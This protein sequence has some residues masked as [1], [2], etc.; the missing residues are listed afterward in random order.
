[1]SEHNVNQDPQGAVSADAMSEGGLRA[2]ADY[3]TL[4]KLW[5]WFDFLILVKLARLRF[6][7]ILAVIGAA[8]L[9]W[10]TAVAYYEKWTRPISGEAQAADP[11]VE[12][13]CPM[14]PQVVTHDPHEKCPICGMNLSKRKKDDT[15]P[16]EA[17]PP[18]VVT[19]LQLSPYKVVTAGVRTWEANYEPL[20]KKLQTVGTVEV[21][22]RRQNR[23]TARVKGRLDKLYVNVTGQ[24]VRRGDPLAD[25]YSPDLVS[26]VQNLLDARREADKELVRDRLRKWGVG[27]DQVKEMERAGKP[28]EH[29]TI[30]S[31]ADGYVMKKYQVEGESVEE[32][33]PLYDVADLSAVWVEAK[34]YEKDVTFLKVGLPV[35]ATA[36]AL[37]NREFVGN[38]A[39]IYPALEPGSRTLKVRF[40]IDNPD[41]EKRPELGLRPKMYATVTIDVPA[42]DLAEQY[43]AA[44]GRVLGVPE[45]AVVYTG[46]QKVVFRQ[47][48][49]TVFDA[50]AV[51]VGPLLTRPDGT[52]FYPV[53]K[54]L[55]AGDHVVT[56]GSYLLDAETRVSASA[57]SIYSGGGGGGPRSGSADLANVRPTTPQDEDANVKAYLAQLSSPDRRLAEAQKVCP[58]QKNRLGTMGTPVKLLLNGEPVFLCCTGCVKD[59]ET[60]PNKTLAAVTE[61]KNGD[62]KPSAPALSAD[63]AAKVKANLAKLGDEDRKLAEA[64]KYCALLRNSVLGLMGK[65]VKV[66]IKRQPVFLCCPNCEDDA[67]ADPD[68]TLKTAEEQKKRAKA[69]GREF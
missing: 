39:F 18:G 59:A 5:W 10:D 4:R 61:M 37:P 31:T 64:Q 16:A 2:P 56:A 67:R 60:D 49:P 32:S 50:V 15:A 52:A 54:G 21:D 45:G 36:D 65:P 24:A 25:I 58:V 6:I 47:E 68:K 66:V 23:I 3:G 34:V 43:A 51:E 38:L 8:I 53:L 63:R 30:R 57:S 26:T 12:Y 29:V 14:H 40:D 22:E 27:D 48:A 11:D 69:E 9:Y 28:I 46:G 41:Q 35:K 33:A 42:A 13:F 1:M 17:L 7:A 62:G 20:V 44:D 19:R 55:E